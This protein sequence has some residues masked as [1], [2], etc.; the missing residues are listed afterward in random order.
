MS[1]AV[2]GLGVVRL[3]ATGP[4]DA[5]NQG[6]QED[7]VGEG[8]VGVPISCSKDPSFAVLVGPEYRLHLSRLFALSRREDLG[9]GPNFFDD[10]EFVHRRLVIGREIL[11]RRVIFFG[12]RNRILTLMLVMAAG[13]AEEL[14]PIVNFCRSVGMHRTVDDNCVDSVVV[15]LGDP[16]DVVC[17]VG[18][19]E[20]LIVNHDIVAFG[21]IGFA[22][23][24]NHGFGSFATFVDNSPFDRDTLVF[25]RHLQRSSLEIVV[26]AATTGYEQNPNW[27][28]RIACSHTPDRGGCHDRHEYQQCLKESDSNHGRT[29]ELQWNS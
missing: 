24:V 23:Q 20:A 18:V 7:W 1:M 21:P 29:R 5:T 14:S 11:H 26:V 8:V 17:I 4:D 10:V 27:L 6:F 22:I 25:S 12:N 15:R 19:S 2:K 9:V 13:H 3:F 28:S 16:S